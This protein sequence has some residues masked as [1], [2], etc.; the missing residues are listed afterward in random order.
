MGVNLGSTAISDL[1]LGDTQIGKAYLGS[2]LV[3][4]STPA[5]TVR[6][7]KFTSAGAQT[8]GINQSSLGTLT[9]NFEYSND[10][11]TW[12]SWDITT[13]LAFGNGVDLYIRGTNNILANSSEYTTFVF[14]TSEPVNC[15][16]NIM[17]LFDYTQDLTAF[18]TAE[19]SA[20]TKAMF[21]NCT[22]LVSAPQLP[23]T[24]L[25]DRCYNLMFWNCT[26]LV[27]P[28]ELPATS[29]AEGCY[30]SMFMRCRVLN[31]APELP[32]TTLA[33]NCY[34]KMFGGCRGL[35]SAP[36]LP[37][38]SIP[39]GAYGVM[40]ESCKSL[41]SIPELPGTSF[42]LNCYTKM[43][44]GCS[45]IKMSTTEGGEYTNEYTFGAIPSAYAIDMFVNTGGTFTGT[46]NQQTY[47]TA[48]TI[49]S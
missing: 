39:T 20:G 34:F 2:E 7:L 4:D 30:H 5:P 36:S 47:Y 48:N 14:S 33:I 44:D 19:G 18:P 11:Q 25:L 27:H 8:L 22:Q 29:L 9:P 31:N 41:A 37:A 49:I 45:L 26:S 16:G 24:T 12:A 43:F 6:A 35:T 42:G 15:S 13:T 46:P 1:R 32:A 28:P 40:F 23:A 10:D 38:L 21:Y 17:H 3:W